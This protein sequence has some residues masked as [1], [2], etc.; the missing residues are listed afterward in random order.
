MANRLKEIREGRDPRVEIYDLAA[1]LRVSV[2]TIRRWEV[3]EIPTK[4]IASLTD[5][6]DVTADHLLGLDR[7]SVA[8]APAA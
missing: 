7:S 2:E 1:H 4:H 5:Y 8:E 6:F 3:G